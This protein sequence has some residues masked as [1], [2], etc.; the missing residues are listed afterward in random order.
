MT[1]TK[2]AVA[3][4]SIIN[5]A[6]SDVLQQSITAAVNKNGTQAAKAFAGTYSAIEQLV[7]EREAWEANAFRTS[8][9]Q[10]YMILQRCFAMY[11]AMSAETTEAKDLR[12]G[13]NSYIDLKA[14]IFNK[15]THTLT[16]IVKC[17]FGAERR[18]VSAYSIVLR[19]ALAKNISA[20]DIAAYIRDNNGVEEIRLAKS[21][22][23]M[24]LKQK[25]VA[26]SSAVS[27]SNYGVFSSTQ[28]SSKLDAGK[29]G[30]N[31]VLI[32]TWQADG[33]ILI[34]TVVESDGALNA[35]LASYF[36][37]YKKAQK[38]KEQ[39]Q[40]AAN[41]SAK[42]SDLVAKAAAEAKQAA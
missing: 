20:L 39:E 15:S 33:S 11:M 1:N 28:L 6:G 29:I 26:A 37:D 27:E 41:D 3:T 4:E 19:S 36:S 18:R 38:P 31:T 23:A 34:R 5:T 21:P 7:N 22:N 30:T 16:K 35:A 2:N 9:E 12:E 24:T 14:L 17:V 10:L 32:G 25:A 42:K 40:K 13:L 8:N